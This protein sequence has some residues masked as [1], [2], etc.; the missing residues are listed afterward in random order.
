MS[1]LVIGASGYIGFAVGQYLRQMGYTVYGLVRKPEQAKR[2]AQNEI[3][4]VVGDGQKPESFESII[5]QV[6]FIIETSPDQ[7][8]NQAVL[9]F[10]KKISTPQSKKVFV[11]TSGVMV[12]GGSQK[13]VDEDQIH[14]S[15]E[16]FIHARLKYEQEVVHSPEIYGIVIRP[17]FVYGFAGGNSGTYVNPWFAVGKNKGKIIIEGN[18]DRCHPWLHIADLAHSFYLSLQHY[19]TASGQIFDIADTAPSYEELYR[20][21]ATIA[22]FP[23]AEVISKPFPENS[24]SAAAV[25]VTVRTSYVKAKSLLGWTPSHPPVV[26]D[27]EATYE[28]WKANNGTDN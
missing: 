13:F 21:A 28:A 26:D 15:P 6:K 1:V 3:H 10:V 7:V 23:N 12:H 18:K 20:K 24:P 27:I 17:G 4:P 8:G 9:E 25:D 5:K 19:I 14:P 22:G 11:F 2:L 16:P